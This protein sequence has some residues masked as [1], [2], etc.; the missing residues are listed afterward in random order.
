MAL[1]QASLRALSETGKTQW[2]IGGQRSCG[3]LVQLDDGLNS[4]VYTGEVPP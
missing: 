1:V 3:E 2:F 4:Q